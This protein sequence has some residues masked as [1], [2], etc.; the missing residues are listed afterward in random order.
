MPSRLYVTLKLKHSNSIEYGYNL[1]R[2]VFVC[3]FKQ[4]NAFKFGRFF[5]I[6]SLTYPCYVRSRWLYYLVGFFMR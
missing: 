1:S 6:A 3:L 5:Y 4:Y 2:K